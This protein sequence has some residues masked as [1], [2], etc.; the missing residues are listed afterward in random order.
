MVQINL[1]IFIPESNRDRVINGVTKYCS[2]C[3]KEFS[4]DEEIYLN[5]N[6]YEYLCSSCT[7]CLSEEL[8]TNQE[9]M[10]DCQDE[11]SLF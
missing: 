5:S 6:N 4:P 11:S 1:D 9:C 7:C 2:K 8:Q 3:Y 10:L